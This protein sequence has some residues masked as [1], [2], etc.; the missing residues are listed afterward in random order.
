[1]SILVACEESQAVTVELRR[2]G[3]KAFSCDILPCS[4]GHKEWHIQGDVLEVLGRKWDM[5]I[6]FPPCQHLACSGNPSRAPK[7]MNGGTQEAEG[8]AFFMKMVN[9]HHIPKIAVENPV[10]VMSSKHKKPSQVSDCALH[11]PTLTHT[12]HHTPHPAHYLH[13]R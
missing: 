4:G 7:K 1:M 8:A 5:L 3:H 12:A 9:A 13:T 6:A 10:G 2:L 11:V